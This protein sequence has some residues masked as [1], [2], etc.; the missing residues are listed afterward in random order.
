MT[1]RKGMPDQEMVRERKVSLRY[2]AVNGLFNGLLAGVIMALYVVLAGQVVGGSKWAYMGYLDI[3]HSGVPGQAILTH[4]SISAAYG[5]LYG[6][7]RRWTRLD[8]QAL[9]PGW[10]AG[11]TYGFLLWTMTVAW[12]LP[13]DNFV[14]G[15]LPAG[16]LLFAHLIYGLV[17]GSGQRP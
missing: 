3:T 15:P 6:L 1:R 10:L 8:Q 2:A 13:K 9:L 14:L 16:Y 11:L 12:I 7:A 5:V 4:L 17:L